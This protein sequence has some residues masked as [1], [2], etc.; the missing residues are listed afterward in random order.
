MLRKT[1]G[2][3]IGALIL[4]PFTAFVFAQTATTSPTVTSPNPPLRP[5][6]HQPV[7]QIGPEGRTLLRGTVDSV[8]TDS[9][10]VKSWGGKWT[11]R[12]G[13]NTQILPKIT[14][15]ISDLSGFKAGDFVGVQGKTADS[16][17]WTIDATLVRNWTERQAVRETIKDI[18]QIKKEGRIEGVGKTFE[19]TTG[20]VSADSFVITL[21]DGKSYTVK[22]SADT[23]VVNKNFL[24]MNLSDI[25]S[26]DRVRFFGTIDTTALTGNASVVRDV[27]VPR[28]T[29]Q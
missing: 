16:P 25:Q 12:V 28:Q 1:A 3:A 13:V 4:I 9:L 19:G 6:R 5:L 7:V 18:K 2:I 8:G 21:P 22:V 24:K 15:G 11:V 20:T 29:G 17:D 27:S 14:G 26:G 10:V 23:K